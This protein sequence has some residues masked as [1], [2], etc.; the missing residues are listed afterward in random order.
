ME[1][2]SDLVSPK[3]VAQAIGVSESS[4][5]RWCDQGLI[6]TVR[7]AG[8]HRKMQISEVMH[9]LRG[10][11]QTLVDP[12]AL[13]LPPASE[14]SELGLTRGRDLLVSALL[15]G[16]ETQARQIVIGLHLAKHPLCVI[17]DDVIASA[18]REIGMRWACHE[19]DPYQERR[20]CEIAR[21]I[22]FDLRRIQ[23]VPDPT[24]L[25]IGGTI[26]GDH[27]VLPSTMAELVLREAG[28]NARTLGTSLP[29]PSF[30]KAIRETNPKL[31]WLSVS[32]IQ[33]SVDF[34]TEFGKL[35][36]VCVETGT[37][38]VVGGRV[39]TE[40]IRQKMS[41]SS[42]CDTMRHLDAF[43]RTYPRTL[44]PEG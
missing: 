12:E 20:G 21:Q 29:I 1:T 17:C 27:Y 36:D 33:P 14:R 37:A 40:A 38:L 18:F 30:I 16:H 13:G 23:R 6:K 2:P 9:F 26:E 35:A 44:V 19:A 32:Y 42:Y 24:L 25:A 31:F 34:L 7:T 4:L 39:L 11:N 10:R 43:A 41:Y 15:A 8:G 28:W 5:K 3:Q 22:L